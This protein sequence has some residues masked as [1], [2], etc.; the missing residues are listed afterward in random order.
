MILP[1]TLDTS[2]KYYLAFIF[3]GVGG[4]VIN[5]FVFGIWK[6]LSQRIA[7]QFRKRY[8][9][10]FITK[11]ASWVDKQNLYETSAEFRNACI[12]I[13]RATGDKVALFYNINGAAISG[14]IFAI[15]VR[16]TF[17]LY[18][19]AL[20]PLGMVAFG[21]FIY[22]LIKRKLDSKECFEKA[23]AHAVEA[24]IQIQTVKMMQGEN[25]Q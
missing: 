16:W 8:M 9:E 5:A 19:I 11:N 17:A 21:Y 18:L 22:V 2:L 23:E 24:S 4:F 14:C 7:F 12:T 3:I 1:S 13:E 25:Y 10:A 20:L 15:S 6:L